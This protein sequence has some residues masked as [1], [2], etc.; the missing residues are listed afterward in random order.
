MADESQVPQQEPVAE[1]QTEAVGQPPA[2]DGELNEFD[3]ATKEKMSKTIQNRIAP[4]TKKKN[5]AEQR[6]AQAEAERDAIKKQHEEMMAKMQQNPAAMT[7]DQMQKMIQEESQKVQQSGKVASLDY[8]INE[9][10]KEDSE[11]GELLTKGNAIPPSMVQF[12]ANQDHINNMP[13]VVKHLLK[14]KGDHAVY[15]S[16]S[17]PA[18]AINFINNLSNKLS[19][20]NQPKPSEFTPNP[21]LSDQSEDNFNVIDY[22]KN[23][24]FNRN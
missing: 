9:A 23:R 22:V 7:P 14:D 19:L 11:L 13:A 17:T 2:E 10:K 15:M 16:S 3:A 8:K 4:I 12:L 5:E 6:A 21:K 1:P 20:N 24:R 18:E